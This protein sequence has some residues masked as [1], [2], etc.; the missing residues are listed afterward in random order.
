MDPFIGEIRMVGFDYAPNNGWL[1]CNGQLLNIS[2]YNALFA[3]LGTTFGGNGQTNFALPD[4]RGR[5]PIHWGAGPGLSSHNM[6]EASGS[7]T[8]TLLQNNM[9][10]HTHNMAVAATAGKTTDP[11]NGY[12]A[13]VNNPN[14]EVP[15]SSFVGSLTNPS[16]LA[17]Y[18]IGTAGG[19]QPHA[20]MQPY[21]TVNFI[22]AYL[23]IYPSRS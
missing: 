11:T 12:L 17:P 13:Q 10:T 4:L 21:L 15:F 7:E 6:G 22:I 14:G 19:N 23:G 2:N 8:V 5:V 16:N 9:P 18:T 1:L 20:N 3:L